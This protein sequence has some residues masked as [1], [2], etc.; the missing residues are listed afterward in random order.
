MQIGIC[1]SFLL[2]LVAVVPSFAKCSPKIPSTLPITSTFFSSD[3]ARNATDIQ[4]DGLSGGTY[5][6]NAD[7]V[8]TYLTCNGYN[9]QAFGDWQFD[10]LNS[11][12]RRVSLSFQNPIPQSN[13]GTAPA[14]PPFNIKNVITHVEDKCS[15]IANG[16]GGWNNMLQMSPGQTFQCPLIVHFF[17]SNGAEYRIYMG[18]NWEPETSFVQVTCN[19]VAAD[20]SGC[21]D[22]FIDPIPVNGAPGQS[23]GRL[24]FFGKRTSTNEGDY[25]FRLH[26]HLTRP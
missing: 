10:A 2:A 4:S 20:N 7:G 26:F 11:P 24:V 22:W 19:S 8:T 5:Y 14:N 17:D 25:Y 12:V 21:N 16:S 1:S 15:Q 3:L 23:I 6:N 18:P 13:G 9:G